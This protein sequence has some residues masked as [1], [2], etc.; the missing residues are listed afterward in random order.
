MNTPSNNDIH[1]RYRLGIND[2]F[3]HF[4]VY[5]SIFPFLQEAYDLACVNVSSVGVFFSNLFRFN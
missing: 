2:I 5:V 3:F 4:F 1:H